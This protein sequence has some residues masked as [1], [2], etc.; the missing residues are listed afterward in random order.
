M[1]H[2]N[3]LH[4]N[5]RFASALSL[6]VAIKLGGNNDDARCWRWWWV[7]VCCREVEVIKILKFPVVIF[8]KCYNFLVTLRARPAASGV[9]ILNS[10]NNSN[11][12]RTSYL[13]IIE[14]ACSTFSSH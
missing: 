1:F 6:S 7:V 14:R 4:A 9:R 10:S 8:H 11:N 2:D 5:C 13:A 3:F 12:K